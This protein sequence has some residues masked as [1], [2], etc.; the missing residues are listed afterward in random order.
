MIQRVL[1]LTAAICLIKP[2]LWTDGLGGALAIIVWLG[3]RLKGP[4]LKKR[5]VP[6]SH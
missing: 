3:S 2:G 1:L 6:G 4:A 5:L